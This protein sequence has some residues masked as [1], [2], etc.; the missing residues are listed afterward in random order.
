MEN[1]TDAIIL[2]GSMLLLIIALTITISSL[3]SLKAETQDM[4]DDR[5]QL[6]ATTDEAGYINYLK[7]GDNAT[8]T[9]GIETIISSIRRLRK[10]DY[11]VYIQ[12]KPEVDVSNLSSDIKTEIDGK[13]YIKIT[14]AGVGGKYVEDKAVTFEIYKRLK[15]ARFSE[16]IGI[17]QN[18]TSEGVSNANKSTYK[19]IT[20]EQI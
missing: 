9:V 4:L 17:Y 5:D 20:Y 19:I 15:S 6:L 16:Y 7:G 2:A 3:T 13:K 10:E 11:T 12:V 14:L 1:A 8:R 18:A